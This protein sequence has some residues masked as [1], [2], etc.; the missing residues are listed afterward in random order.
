MRK[1]L[2]T[3]AAVLPFRIK[4]LIY[5]RV[6]GYEIGDGCYIG[7]SFIYVRKL[8][9]ESGSR[10]GKFNFV[11]EIPLLHLCSEASI[12][13]FN[14]FAF[15]E[16]HRTSTLPDYSE[17]FLE[18]GRSAAITS[19]HYF[20]LGDSIK[21]GAFT[22]IAGKASQFWTHGIDVATGVQS[23]KPLV[24]GDYC[25]ICSSVRLIGGTIIGDRCVIG[26]GS[27]VVKSFL[28]P[29]SL[30]GGNP[31]TFIKK[32]PGDGAYFHRSERDVLWA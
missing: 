1:L 7:L 21:I 31:A 2:L 20:D 19:G 25:L 13:S 27:V 3:L 11:K 18:L 29:Y 24:V 5:I 9:M 4:R 32:M 16:R 28:E 15:V 22:T 8:R 23:G 10:I 14:H 30:V 6:F 12:G 26:A 17:I